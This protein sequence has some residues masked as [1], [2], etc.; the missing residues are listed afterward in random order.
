MNTGESFYKKAIWRK[1]FLWKKP[2]RCE[3]TGKLLWF[4]YVY[5]GVAVWTGPH[6]P[7]IEFRY[8]D[9][10]EHIIWLLEK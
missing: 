8:H 6:D 7:V 1:R 9:S 5:E 2:R 3:L 4:R 10:K